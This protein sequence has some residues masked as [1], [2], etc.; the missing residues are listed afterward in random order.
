M[1][2]LSVCYGFTAAEDSCDTGHVFIQEKTCAWQLQW[3][4]RCC[5]LFG[6]FFVLFWFLFFLV[7]FCFFWLD[8]FW[9]WTSFLW[10]KKTRFPVCHLRYGCYLYRVFCIFGQNS[11]HRAFF[12]VPSTFSVHFLPH[13]S[14]FFFW[15]YNNES[16]T[17]HRVA[18]LDFAVWSFFQ[19]HVRSFLHAAV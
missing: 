3:I 19:T 6:F 11:W 2:L 7:L 5:C 14:W 13:V 12:G 9:W 15:S 10:G 1:W 17:V 4:L 16:Y 8:F 18:C